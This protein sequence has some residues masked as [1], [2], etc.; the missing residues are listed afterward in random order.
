MNIFGHGVKRVLS[1]ILVFTL[2]LLVGCNSSEKA[3]KVN[4]RAEVNHDKLLISAFAENKGNIFLYDD[5]SKSQTA[6]VSDRGVELT[7]DLSE[8]SSKVAYTD[9]LN[10]SDPWQIYLRDL[11]S[12]KTYQVTNSKMGMARVRFIGNKQMFFLLGT[13]SGVIKVANVNTDTKSTLVI[14]EKDTD[15]ELEAFDINKN[16]LLVSAVSTSK[17]LEL[18]KKNNGVNKPMRRIIFEGDLKGE[19]LR[20]VATVEASMIISVSYNHE[21]NKVIL[22]G[23][24]VNGNEGVGIYEL[25]LETHDIT[26]ILTDK[27]ISSTKDSIIKGFTSRIIVRYSKDGSYI[28]FVG[29]PKESKIVTIEG[30]QCYPQAIYSYNIKTKEM[31]EVFKPKVASV[32]SDFQVK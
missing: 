22:C 4:A 6:L 17:R 21:G 7:C 30:I 32:I 31:K 1:I 9:A 28:Y 23:E 15:R 5:K 8:D 27:I 2:I 16:K 14:D 19:N 18:W 10:D 25:S 26:P 11:N 29:S 12:K 3:N 20:E 13:P 24:N